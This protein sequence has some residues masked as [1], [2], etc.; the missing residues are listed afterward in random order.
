MGIVS[1]GC[2]ILFITSQFAVVVT[3][4]AV[5][6]GAEEGALEVA[7]EGEAVVTAAST[8]EAAVMAPTAGIALIERIPA[9]NRP[10]GGLPFRLRSHVQA[11]AREVPT[12]L[13]RCP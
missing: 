2:W 13:R 3:E 1:I 12:V 8:G 9:I 10:T 11:A 4:S 7:A 6:M 5:A